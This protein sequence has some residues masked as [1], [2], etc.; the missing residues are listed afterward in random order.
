[1]KASELIQELAKDIKANGDRD[2]Y[3]WPSW[4]ARPIRVVTAHGARDGFLVLPDDMTDQAA[5]YRDRIAE[6]ET[7]LEELR[8]QLHRCDT[9]PAPAPEAP[10][11]AE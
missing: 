5:E 1:M 6:L 7:D 8:A 3:V 11:A 2:A 4:S 10:C 9:I